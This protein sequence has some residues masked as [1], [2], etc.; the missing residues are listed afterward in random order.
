MESSDTEKKDNK[1]DD[2][3]CLLSWQGLSFPDEMKT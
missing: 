2:K 3:S 1:K